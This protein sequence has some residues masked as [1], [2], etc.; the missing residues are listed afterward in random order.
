M[1][2]TEGHSVKGTN[3]PGGRER[4]RER[5]R[6]RVLYILYPAQPSPAPHLTSSSRTGVEIFILQLSIWIFDCTNC[7]EEKCSCSAFCRDRHSLFLVI[8]SKQ[9]EIKN[10]LHQILVSNQALAGAFLK[11]SPDS[12]D[13]Y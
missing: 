8:I 11:D 13:F 6:E 10:H 5:E 7:I 1:I 4:E 3:C 12:T 2:N 9:T